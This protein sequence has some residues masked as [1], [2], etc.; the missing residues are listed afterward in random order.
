MSSTTTQT[1]TVQIDTKEGLIALP[2]GAKVKD[3]DGD[4][5]RRTESGF[6]TGHGSDGIPFSFGELA[7][8][9]PCTLENPEILSSEL[10]TGDPVTVSAD[11]FA[12]Y[13][14]RG[15]KGTVSRV[16]GPHLYVSFPDGLVLPF[17]PNELRKPLAAGDRIPSSSELRTLPDGTVVVSDRGEVRKRIQ[18]RWFRPGS[19]AQCDLGTGMMASRG[20]LRI[21]HVAY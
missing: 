13:I 20:E 6:I 12:P 15:D 3:R 8:Y 14:K 1:R 18:G 4:R 2:V 9:L 7:V 21:A 11:M 19:T 10:K 17:L 16:V 5:Y